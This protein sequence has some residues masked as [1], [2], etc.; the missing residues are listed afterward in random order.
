MRE[1]LWIIAYGNPDRRDDGCA[2]HVAERLRSRLGDRGGPAI[3]TLQQ[4][5]PALAVDLG[6]ARE[7]VFVDAAV[8]GH[9]TG[10]G[11]QRVAP[12]QRSLPLMT[13]HLPPSFLLGLV[14]AVWGRC[15]EAWLVSVE[16]EDFG[17]G[18]GLSPGAEKRVE[19]VSRRIA[20]FAAGVEEG[21]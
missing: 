6:A 3:R 20:S 8:Q 9:G 21:E 1:G 13:H 2:W 17:I 18:E 15:P 5:D 7:V 4:L 10:S 16:G 12:E 11:W 19:E 14:T